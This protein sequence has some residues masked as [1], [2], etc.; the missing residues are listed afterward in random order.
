MRALGAS[1]ILL[2]GAGF[3]FGEAP[4]PPEQPKSGPGGSHYAHQKAVRS[5]HGTG[6]EQFWLFE[7][8][9]PTPQSAPVVVFNHG[10]MAIDPG[11]YLGWIQHIC[12]RGAIVVFPKYQEGPFTAPWT[13]AQSTT[14]ATKAALQELKNPGHVAPDLGKFA[15]VGHSAGGALAA[16]MAALAASA[17]LPRPRAVMVVEPGRGAQKARNPFFPAA[18]YKK[19]PADALLLVVVGDQDRMVGD[20]SAKDIFLGAEAIPRE[21]KNY[22]VVRTD[23]HGEPP[24]VADHMSPCS[25]IAPVWFLPGR[26]IDAIDYYAYWKLFDSLTDCAFFGK[27]REFALGNTPQ[28]RFMGAWSDG[29]PVQELVV[30]DAP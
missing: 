28:Q 9:E 23:R 17:G 2:L 26:R 24:L 4:R 20:A 12:R 18:D 16:D 14:N 27:N 11:I 30:T 25:P 3:A 6:V 7:P 13:F 21:N 1:L 15:I 29:T 22:I 10:W 8:A 5:V 19:I